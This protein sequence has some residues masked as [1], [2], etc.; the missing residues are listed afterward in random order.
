[1]GRFPAGPI[2]PIDWP[3]NPIFPPTPPPDFPPI[4]SP[5]PFPINI[6]DPDFPPID[7]PDYDDIPLDPVPPS[8]PD[9]CCANYKIVLPKLSFWLCFWRTFPF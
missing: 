7:F 6:P 3:I 4:I 9:N 8:I 5:N 2:N 1:M